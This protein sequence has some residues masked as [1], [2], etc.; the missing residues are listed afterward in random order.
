MLY[1]LGINKVSKFVYMIIANPLQQNL[2]FLVKKQAFHELI[3]V[4]NL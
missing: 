2:K 1:T 4:S 3:I